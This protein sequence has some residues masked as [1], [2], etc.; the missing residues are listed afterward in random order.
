MKLLTQPFSQKKRKVEGIEVSLYRLV[1]E[2]GYVFK[3][4]ISGESMANYTELDPQVLNTESGA[5][6]IEKQL[7]ENARETIKGLK[8]QQDDKKTGD[9]DGEATRSQSGEEGGE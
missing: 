8:K 5:G 1:K 2:M 6:E 7:V 3:D 4:P 9:Q